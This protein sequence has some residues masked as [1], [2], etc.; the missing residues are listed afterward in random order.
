MHDAADVTVSWS[1]GGH[2]DGIITAF[3]TQVGYSMQ[4]SSVQH[5]N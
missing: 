4:V 1:L 2:A 5:P 3:S